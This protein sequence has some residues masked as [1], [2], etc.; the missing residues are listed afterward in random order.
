MTTKKR[1]K[2]KYLNMNKN[3]IMKDARNMSYS[4]N[5]AFIF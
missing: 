5:T 2:K 3:V 1:D 4:G